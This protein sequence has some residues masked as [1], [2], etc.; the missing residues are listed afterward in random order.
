MKIQYKISCKQGS[1]VEEGTDFCSTNLGESQDVQ[2][3]FIVYSISNKDVK[4][5]QRILD[6]YIA[7]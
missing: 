1:V 5:L 2:C 4:E 6:F 7:T 3:E